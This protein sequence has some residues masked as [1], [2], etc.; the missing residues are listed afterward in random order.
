MKKFANAKAISSDQ[1][2]GHG[3]EMDFETRSTL[4]RFEGQS[5]IGSADLFG[6]GQSA[7]QQGFSYSDHVPEMADI[8]DSLRQGASKVADKLSNISSSFS[9][10]LGVSPVRTGR[11]GPC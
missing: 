7:Q 1:F 8:K 6:N 9:A 2:F 11:S 10:Y 5:A 4:S 3:Q